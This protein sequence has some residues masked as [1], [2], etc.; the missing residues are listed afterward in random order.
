M[1]EM[2][3]YRGLI[4]NF[5]SPRAEV[6]VQAQ[7]PRL[8]V[9]AH[10]PAATLLVFT[11]V[12]STI[13]RAHPPAAH[14]GMT[15]YVLYLFIGLVAWNFFNNVVTGGMASLIGAGPLLKKI[16]FPPYAPVLGNAFSALVQTLIESGVL[17]IVLVALGNASWT[18]IV[19]PLILALLLVFAAG[20][21]LVFALFNVYYRDVGY[22]V[23]VLLR[24]CSS[25][26]RSS[27]RRPC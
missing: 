14:N 11:A 25:P 2:W 8:G 27:G 23:G 5:A 6:E 17:L 19:A 16:Y 15:T 4:G 9:V 21:G 26:R 22:I 1:A 10:Q 24:W 18:F 13:F 20:V 3:R 7:R 12:F